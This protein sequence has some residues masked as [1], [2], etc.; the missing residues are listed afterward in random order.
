MPT[1]LIVDDDRHTRSL[2]ERMLASEPRLARLGVRVVHAG[3][4]LE[5]LRLFDSERPDAVVTD[6]LMPRMDGFRLCKE[7]RAR[8]RDVA[9]L[10]LSAA[11]R[12]SA[13][14]SRLREEVGATYFAKPYQMKELIAALER[15]LLRVGR[16]PSG[17]EAAA[18]GEPAGP[19]PFEPRRGAFAEVPLPRLLFELYEAKATGS[20]EIRRGRIEKR[21]DLVVGHPVA[22]SSNERSEAL[23][24]FL[25]QRGVI[26]ET[27]HQTAL[28][29]ARNEDKKLGEALMQLGHLG[30][31]ELIKHLTAQA[32]HKIVRALRW[33]DGTWDYRPNREL[34]DATKGNAL[35]PVAVVFLGLRKSA[36]LEGAARAALPLS[37]HVVA[38]TD[39]GAKVQPVVARVFGAAFAEA[40]ERG[41]AFESFLRRPF[42]PAH[43]LP[44]LEALLVTG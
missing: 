7:L 14:P 18:G 24:H 38:L 23:G 6:L 43:S 40:L 29:L 31:A 35:D 42:E 27:L 33:P 12:D 39:R 32:R 44:A 20:V 30:S 1:V 3:D 36:T 8:S 22:V 25:V 28:E 4:G 41:P 9:I 34:L 26:S 5:G 11:Y 21:I 2:L 13:T 10:V 19:P 15:R 16:S 37:G 17:M